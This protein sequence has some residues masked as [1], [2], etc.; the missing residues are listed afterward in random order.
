MVDGILELNGRTE[1]RRR[2][3]AARA[4]VCFVLALCLFSSS[5]SSDSAGRRDIGR[6]CGP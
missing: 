5:D 4:V 1:R 2:L 6:S 3:L